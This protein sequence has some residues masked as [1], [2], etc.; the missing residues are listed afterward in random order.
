MDTE[1]LREK[2]LADRAALLAKRTEIVQAIEWL[3]LEARRLK[4][5]SLS[6]VDDDL[7]NIA[8][9]ARVFGI[10][11]EGCVVDLSRAPILAEEA[12]ALLT[13]PSSSASS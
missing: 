9:A 11:M 6:A 7:E 5:E 8:A 3:K 4:N 2:L 1:A 12:Q 10:Q 13:N